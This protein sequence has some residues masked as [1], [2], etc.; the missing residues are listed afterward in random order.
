VV[1]RTRT[2]Y[3]SFYTIEPVP[4]F[5]KQRTFTSGHYP[6]GTVLETIRSCDP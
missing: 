3:V 5:E 6:L 4:A 1:T 2:V